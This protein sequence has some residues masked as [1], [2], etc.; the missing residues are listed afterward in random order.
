MMVRFI[1]SI[2]ITNE[3][4]GC[5][6]LIEVDVKTCGELDGKTRPCQI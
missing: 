5:A 2:D 6:N 1:M 3:V 4:P